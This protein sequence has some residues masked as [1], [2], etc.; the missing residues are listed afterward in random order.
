MESSTALITNDAAVL[1]LL[2]VLLGTVFWTSHSDHPVFK[3]FYRYVPALLV[4]YFLPSLFNSFG[5]ISGEQ[6]RLYFVSSRYLLP[7]TLVLLTLSIDFQG[8]K[9][10]G[11]KALIMFFTGTVS[12]V[13]GGPLAIMLF[14]LIAPDLVG[15]VGP[16][17]VWRGLT[18][19][20]GSWIGGGANQT[21][22]KEVYEVGDQLFSA[23]VA[24]DVIVANIWMAILLYMAGEAPRLDAKLGADTTALEELRRKVQAFQEKHAR[25][26]SLNDLMII[27]AVGFGA[28]GI[29]H[30][31]ADWLAPWIGENF[32]AL[33]RLSLASQFFWLVVVATT[34][35][36]VLSATRVRELEG[37]GASKVGSAMLYILIASIG[38]NMDI[39][40][41]VKQPGLFAVG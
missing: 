2:A 22:M 7:A 16:D 32:P 5:I 10:L 1:G 29:S 18:T 21:A 27:I 38:M 19:V 15:G 31:I 3:K 8:I 23:M 17:A 4:C 20:A 9:K 12:I 6:S 40:A 28:M 37:A 30:V 35:G 39:T 24:V 13:L 34:I 25:I 11:P 26:P 36:M 41:V 14:S 33:N